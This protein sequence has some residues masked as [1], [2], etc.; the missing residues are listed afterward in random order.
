M[1]EA[2]L[3]DILAGRAPEHRV[4][5]APGGS[6]FIVLHMMEAANSQWV[7]NGT[8]YAADRTLL[9]QLGDPQWHID[10]AIW[11]GGDAVTLSMRRFPGD[12][13]GL[14]LL[15]DIAGRRALPESGESVPFAAL[16]DWLEDW[17]RRQGGRR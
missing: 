13:P 6:H 3:D 4:L 12:T 16:S 2:R 15:L 17:Y 10:Q 11:T 5:M 7:K 14:L 8:L 9:A 1:T